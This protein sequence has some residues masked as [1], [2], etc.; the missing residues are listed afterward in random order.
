MSLFVAKNVDIVIPR[1][2]GL[3]SPRRWRFIVTLLVRVGFEMH[4]RDHSIDG[5]GRASGL[6]RRTKPLFDAGGE[7]SSFIR[8]ATTRRRLGLMLRSGSF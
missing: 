3:S 7:I 6:A 2:P 5:N 4:H 1:D 8:S